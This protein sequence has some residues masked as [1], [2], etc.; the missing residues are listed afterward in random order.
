[1]PLYKDGGIGVY[2]P[3]E[4]RDLKNTFLRVRESL[5]FDSTLQYDAE[6]LAKTVIN[7]YESGLTDPIDIAE[8][9]YLSGM[10][11]TQPVLKPCQSDV[12]AH[13]EA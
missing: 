1:M 12:I 6:Y 11:I 13:Q 5:E 9:I 3:C 7:L 8:V 4:L 2:R 10:F